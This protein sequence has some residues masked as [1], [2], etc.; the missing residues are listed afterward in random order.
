MTLGKLIP[1]QGLVLNL[2][3]LKDGSSCAAGRVS[4]TEG[5]VPKWYT[6]QA[7][8]HRLEGPQWCQAFPSSGVLTTRQDVPVSA[9][10][11]PSE[12]NC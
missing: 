2:G 12:L 4:L 11:V 8:S 9:V 10:R 3:G 5:R 1:T 7:T 6:V